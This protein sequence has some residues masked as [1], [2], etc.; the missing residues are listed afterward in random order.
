MKYKFL[1]MMLVLVLLVGSV[2]AISKNYDHK[3]NTVTLSNS[4][5]GIPTSTLAEV[6]LLTPLDNHVGLGYQRVAEFE[7]TGKKDLNDFFGLIKTYNKNQYDNGN[8]IELNTNLDFKYKLIENKKVK[9]YICEDI[10]LSNGTVIDQKCKVSGNHIEVIETWLP[11]DKKT[12]IK[13]DEV[14]IIGLYT[15]TEEGDYIE[16]IPELLGKEIKEWAAWSASLNTG[17]V[18][19]YNMD[20][21]GNVIDALGTNNGTANTADNTTGKILSGYNFSSG[22]SDYI[23]I[24]DNPS[25]N[26][27]SAMAIS[28]WT[29][30]DGTGIGLFSKELNTAWGA[31]DGEPGQIRFKVVGANGTGSDTE[32]VSG[33][34]LNEWH[35]MVF[36]YDGDTKYFYL[37]GALNSTEKVSVGLIGSNSNNL[38]IGS[39]NNGDNSTR[40]YYAGKIDLF[41]LWSRNLTLSEVTELYDVGYG[42]SYND[43]IVA[44]PTVTLNS[45][46][47]TTNTT[48]QIVAFNSTISVTNPANV[49]LIIDGTYNE[50]NSS[51]ILGDY[52]F[53]KTLSLGSHTWNVESCNEGGCSNSTERNITIK[54]YLENSYSFNVSTFETASETFYLN[55]S[56][57]GATP[58]S[59]KLIYNGTSYTATVTSTGGNNFNISKTIDIPT[60]PENKPFYINYTV[61]GVEVSGSSQTQEVNKTVFTL[62]N[63]TYPI[64]YLNTSF[65]DEAD[66]TTINASILTSTF[67]YYLG[68]GTINK[69]YTYV[70]N[71]LN[72]NYGFCSNTNLTLNVLPYMQYKQGTAYPQRVWQPTAQSYTNTTVNKTLYLLGTADGIYV[73][74]QI[75]NSADQTLSGVEVVATRTISGSTVTVGTGITSASGT[76]TLWLNSDFSHTFTFTKTGYTTYS[77]SEAPT[78]TSYTITMSGGT[79]A[80]AEDYT[81]GIKTY[82]NPGQ[83]ELFNDTIYSFA[84]NV[85]SSYWDLTNFGFNLRLA[86]GTIVGS[87]TSSTAGTAASLNYDVDNQTIIYMDY[88]WNILGNYTNGTKYW[89]VTNTEYSGWSIK[90]FFTD[91]NAYIG[92]GLFGL[93]DFGK[94]LIVFL[95]LFLTVGVMSWKYGATS[96]IAISAM[97]F[98]IVFFMDIVIKILP[99]IRGINHLLTYVTGLALAV[100]VIGEVSRR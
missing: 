78:Q 89:T 31:Y 44:P 7:V 54:D 56:T 14:I 51:I 24:G 62:C 29:I 100:I 36:M 1:I 96:P 55:V 27:S 86:N 69:S 8:E 18:S 42:C 58:T 83:G 40:N 23:N 95:I 72:Y 84:F 19:Y 9:D 81:R 64:Q 98:A 13:K 21:A 35:H 16:W 17:L 79:T 66:L 82:I 87:G 26:F 10:K 25:L 63:A 4:F 6:K 30:G 70:N 75:I 47:N 15:N 39:L 92:F 99:A 74:F 60:T 3:T 48:N 37:D 41:G 76:V 52:L 33:V 57:S 53:T 12:K 73:T 32:V 50:T 49:S 85:T 2:S 46:A 20:E 71:S 94:Y 90:T 34:T 91:L 77:Y 5:L 97:T 67:T 38:A 59:G 22:N 45:P 11:F 65:Q 68:T 43:C 28:L 93:D 80:A 88:N 61:N